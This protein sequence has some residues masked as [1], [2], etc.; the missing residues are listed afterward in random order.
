MG[1]SLAVMLG[2]TH[3]PVGAKQAEMAGPPVGNLL[4]T[5]AKKRSRWEITGGGME[6]VGLQVVGLE[7]VE[8][9]VVIVEGDGAG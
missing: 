1:R 5:A 7:V 8:V 4:S 9:A 3:L 2:R 6:V